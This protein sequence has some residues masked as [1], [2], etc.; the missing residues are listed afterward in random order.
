MNEAV[1]MDRAGFDRMITVLADRGYEVVGPTIRASAIVYDTIDSSADLPIGW[2]DHQ[3]P[4]SYR[5]ENRN[6]GKLFGYVVG[7]DSWKQ[8]LNPSETVIWSGELTEKGITT[9]PTP[10]EPRYAFVGVRP[11]ELAALGILDHVLT[12]DGFLPTNQT[13][14]E[15]RRKAFIVAVNCTE[16]GGTCF[17]DSVGTGPAATSGYDLVITEITSDNDSRLLIEAGT[18][19]GADVLAATGD[20]ETATEAATTLAEDLL[21]AAA[22]AMGRTLDTEDIKELLYGNAHHPRW[23]SI[24][25]RCLSCTNCTLVCP[26]CFCHT[27]EDSQ[28]LAAPVATRTR[29]W[30]SCFTL[31]FSYLHGNAVRET[32]SARYRQWMTHKLA[33]WIDQYGSLGCVGCGRCI[34][35]C[36]VGID[37]TEEAAAIR[38]GDLR[39]PASPLP[40]PGGAR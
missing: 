1:V 4:G 25:E 29:K 2:T 9:R 10:P 18:E 38:H 23:A 14:A 5:L 24:A 40:T 33:S 19:R 34:T 12:P 11:C 3:E 30:D 22:G 21:A 15:R 39:V 13:Y 27:V 16:P 36:P 35:W 7:Q 28:E 37:I 17:C 8:F 6:D 20:L 32:T 26:T 31:D